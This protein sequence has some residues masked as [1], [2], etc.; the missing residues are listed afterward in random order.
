MNTKEALKAGLSL[1]SSV[2]PNERILTF[3]NVVTTAGIICIFFSFSNAYYGNRVAGL[4][5]FLAVVISDFIDG[6][7][8]RFIESKWP[9]YGISRVGEIL[10][11]L[12]D[13]GVV[14]VLL[15]LNIWMAAAVIFFET[16]EIITAARVRKKAGRHIVAIESKAIT[17]IQFV[18]IGAFFLIQE[19]SFAETLFASLIATGSLLRFITY[20]RLLYK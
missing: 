19:D 3:P 2:P 5:F 13:K 9:G 11:P 18:L 20:F 4:I 17:A 7:S 1:Q 8:A 12:R 16:I 15:P 10:D 6:F 14:V